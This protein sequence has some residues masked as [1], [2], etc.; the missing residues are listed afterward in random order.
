M[1]EA[2]GEMRLVDTQHASAFL[3]QKVAKPNR[4]ALMLVALAVIL[5]VGA[6]VLAVDYVA[7]GSDAS[8]LLAVVAIVTIAFVVQA[9]LRV[10]AF[11][12]GLRDR[13]V[14][15]TSV[16]LYRLREDGLHVSGENVEMVVNWRA[17]SEIALGPTFWCVIGPGIGFHLPRTFFE[18]RDAERAFIRGMLERMDESA[19]SRSGDA[20]N[21]VGVW[22]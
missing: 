7:P 9:R 11:F 21:F 10:S 15:E 3:F 18:T 4:V 19:R 16:G 1:L 14:S 6:S 17:V 13:G 12:R 8:A 20:V 2:S 22:G 5:G